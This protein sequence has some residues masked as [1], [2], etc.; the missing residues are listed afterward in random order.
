MD[1]ESH[2]R[3]NIALTGSILTALPPI[4][5]NPDGLFIQAFAETTKIPDITPEMLTMIPEI[6][7]IHLWSRF[8]P[9]KKI[10]SA[11]ASTK[12]AVPSQEN[13]IPM[14]APACFINAG[15]SNPSSKESTVPETAP[16][17]KKMA[18]PLL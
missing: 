16:T 17:A 4:Q 10:P 7:C 9:Y 2:A 3:L 5:S 12:K 6:Q 1:S 8:Q 18:T 14:M 13:G 15:Q 11:I